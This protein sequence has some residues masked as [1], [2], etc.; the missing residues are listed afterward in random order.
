[1][2]DLEAKADEILALLRGEPGPFLE[3]ETSFFGQKRVDPN[4]KDALM[5]TDMGGM[6]ITK[7]KMTYG[8]ADALAAR[9]DLTDYPSF[10]RGLTPNAYWRSYEKPQPEGR[11]FV[12]EVWWSIYS[13]LV[14]RG[15]LEGDPKSYK[16]SMEYLFDHVLDRLLA[17]GVYTQEEGTRWYN[18][19][20]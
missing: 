4:M 3:T 17:A 15:Y 18:E 5:E 9:V 19:T 2:T 14:T 6:M 20:A 10:V 16:N 13:F 12:G 1:M 7:A 8:E 11:H